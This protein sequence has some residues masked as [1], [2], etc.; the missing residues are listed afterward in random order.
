MYRAAPLTLAPALFPRP[1]P[2]VNGATVPDPTLGGYALWDGAF[3][4]TLPPLP[5]GLSATAVADAVS[6]VSD[7]AASAAS[8]ASGLVGVA[9]GLTGVSTI[10][11]EDAAIIG[12]TAGAIN[13]VPRSQGVSSAK[14]RSLVLTSSDARHWVRFRH[15]L[16]ER[17]CC[18]TCERG[19]DTCSLILI[20]THI[21]IYLRPHQLVREQ[22]DRKDETRQRG[23]KSRRKTSQTPPPSTAAATAAATA[24]RPT[25]RQ[26]QAS[27]RGAPATPNKRAQPLSRRQQ[28]AIFRLQVMRTDVQRSRRSGLPGVLKST[29]TAR[30]AFGDTFNVRRHF[31]RLTCHVRATLLLFSSATLTG[32]GLLRRQGAR[33]Y[34]CFP[35]FYSYLFTVCCAGRAGDTIVVFPFSILTC[36]P[37]AAPAGRA[38]S[39]L[40]G[41]GLTVSEEKEFGRRVAAMAAKERPKQVRRTPPFPPLV[42]HAALI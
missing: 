20:S 33:H 40:F 4:G 12:A 37:C 30:H 41:A 36:L 6:S 3:E 17:G 27:A 34:C 8:A 32:H 35:L 11:L 25:A 10:G 5:A 26:S 2:T 23:R 16:W 38:L 1:P 42:G 28:N 21:S 7:A 19:D 39:P 9:G 15:M 31:D 22:K 29:G 14:T 24:V 13:Q 18:Y